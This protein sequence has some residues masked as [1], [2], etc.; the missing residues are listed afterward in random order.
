MSDTLHL[1]RLQKI[2]SQIDHST[3]RL[4]EIEKIL[5]DNSELAEAQAKL[6]SADKHLE[7]AK[8]SLKNAEEAVQAQNLKIEQSE[9]T[10]YGGKI[11]NPKE[12][13]DIQN[14]IAALK[15]YLIVLEEQQLEAMLALEEAEKIHSTAV[16]EFGTVNLANIQQLSKLLGEKDTLTKDIN[17]LQADRQIAINTIQDADINLYEQLRQQR[18]GLAVVLIEDKACSAC[19]TT[20]TPAL[21]QAARLSNQITRCPTCGRI[22]YAD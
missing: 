7:E 1:Y 19:G 10:L 6:T 11:Q 5:A 14:E 16:S 12:L 9:S 22:L 21:C 8:K 3:N 20:L 13:Q 17:R 4:A 15:R 18:R 2:D